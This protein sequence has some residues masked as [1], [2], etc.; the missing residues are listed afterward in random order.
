LCPLLDEDKI[1]LHIFM[2]KAEKILGN[3]LLAPVNHLFVILAVLDLIALLL[4]H[5]CRLMYVLNIRS[6]AD[7]R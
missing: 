5:H 1:S 2:I 6:T 7:P 3:Q 4:T